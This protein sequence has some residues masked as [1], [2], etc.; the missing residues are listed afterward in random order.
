MVFQ[1]KLNGPEDAQK[2]NR[3]AEKCPFDVWLH[4]KSGQADAK[5]A[6]GLMLLALENDLKLVVDEEE[7]VDEK[8]VRREFGDY[9]V[10]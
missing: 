2:L 3:I 9:I 5:S 10:D 1:I 8:V 4:G 7:G 6:L